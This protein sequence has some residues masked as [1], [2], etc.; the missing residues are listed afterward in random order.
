MNSNYKVNACSVKQFWFLTKEHKPTEIGITMKLIKNASALDLIKIVNARGRKASDEVL[1]RYIIIDGVITIDNLGATAKI[2]RYNL[3]DIHK[4]IKTKELVGMKQ[5]IGYKLNCL[6]FISPEDEVYEAMY[7]NINR[8][9][10]ISLKLTNPD[11]WCI[12]TPAKNRQFVTFGNQLGKYTPA[13]EKVVYGFAKPIWACCPLVNIITNE[14]HSVSELRDSLNKVK[15]Y[16]DILIVT[17][18]IS[19]EDNDLAIK[20]LKFF[21]VDTNVN[22]EESKLMLKFFIDCREVEYLPMSV[23]VLTVYDLYHRTILNVNQVKYLCDHNQIA[24]YDGLESCIF[25]LVYSDFIEEIEYYSISSVSLD[26]TS[27][28]GKD[29]LSTV[30][31]EQINKI[32]L[33]QMLEYGTSVVIVLDNEKQFNIIKNWYKEYLR[34]VLEDF[35]AIDALEFNLKDKTF[36]FINNSSGDTALADFYFYDEID[37]EM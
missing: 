10:D 4:Y 33:F 16:N 9:G 3:W 11:D 5:I 29:L 24:G 36:K 12:I 27:A 35:S 23:D 17:N 31:D 26:L 20:T 30:R 8:F 18:T 6:D 19:K 7:K 15:S 34:P 22:K 2:K 21:G 1:D 28:D 13:G 37:F 32:N 14:E 25:D